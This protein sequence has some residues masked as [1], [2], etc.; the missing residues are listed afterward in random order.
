MRKADPVLQ[1][2]IMKVCVIAPDDYTGNVVGDL[3]SRRGEIQGMEPRSGATQVD[4]FVPLGNMFG[5]A[6]DL[7]SSTQGRGQYTME[8]SHYAEVPKSIAEE[9]ISGRTKKD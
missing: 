9:I 7:R 6:T 2:P 1:E 5:Y 4:A 3:S 8:P